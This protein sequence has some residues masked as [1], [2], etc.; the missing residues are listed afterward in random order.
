MKNNK[1]G[2]RRTKTENIVSRR[3]K[4][5]SDIW[6]EPLDSRR[7]GMCKKKKPGDCGKPGCFC[8]HS[9]KVC[10]IKTHKERLADLDFQEDEST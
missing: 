3:K 1:R 10:G 9:N 2:N 7:V 4:V 5:I 8:C 6:K